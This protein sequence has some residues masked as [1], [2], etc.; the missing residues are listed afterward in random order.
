MGGTNVAPPRG[1]RHLGWYRPQFSVGY[2]LQSKALA[3]HL[4]LKSQREG[5]WGP[6]QVLPSA[7]CPRQASDPCW[8]Q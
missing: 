1:Q 7:A 4:P 2:L 3:A 6:Q 8:A 5:V